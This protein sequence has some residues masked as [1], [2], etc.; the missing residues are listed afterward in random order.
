MTL[1]QHVLNSIP[2]YLLQACNPPNSVLLQL[3]RLF[4]GFLCGDT[5]GERL[6]NKDHGL[7]YVTLMKKGV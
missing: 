7:H 2:C 5:E 1:I 4:A 3:E 6:C